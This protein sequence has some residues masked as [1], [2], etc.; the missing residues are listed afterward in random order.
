[1]VLRIGPLIVSNESFNTITC[2]YSTLRITVSWNKASQDG[3]HCSMLYFKYWKVF[4]MHAGVTMCPPSCYQ[5]SVHNTFLTQQNCHFDAFKCFFR[6]YCAIYKRT[7]SCHSDAW[8]K[9]PLFHVP[10]FYFIFLCSSDMNMKGVCLN[11][12]LWQQITCD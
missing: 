12:W 6:I 3:R 2:Y 7:V 8:K 4:P 11:C 5:W 9:L 10:S 1:M